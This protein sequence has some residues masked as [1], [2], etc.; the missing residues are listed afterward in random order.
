MPPTGG[1]GIDQLVNG[2]NGFSQYSGWDRLPAAE[3]R[4]I[5]PIVG[6][7]LTSQKGFCCVHYDR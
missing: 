5:R 4:D 6:G 7:T 3:S 1:L 2:A